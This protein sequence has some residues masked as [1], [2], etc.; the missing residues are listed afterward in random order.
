MSESTLIK[1]RIQA[2]VWEGILTT[3][4]DNHLQP[5]IVVTHLDE[6][7]HGVSVTEDEYVDGQFVVKVPI[8]SNLLSDGVQT[9]VISDRKSGEKLNSFSIVTG[10]PLEDDIRAEVDLLRAELDMMKRAFRRHCLETM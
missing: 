3:A 10:Q 8:P 9:F 7:V 2:G 1:A 6:A 5:E 4:G